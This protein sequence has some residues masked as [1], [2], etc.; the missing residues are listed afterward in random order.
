MSDPE[1][2][3]RRKDLA[4]RGLPDSIEGRV[5]PPNA[6]S[7]GR[8]Q[9][10]PPEPKPNR[11]MMMPLEGRPIDGGTYAAFVLDGPAAGKWAVQQ[12]HW[13]AVQMASARSVWHMANNAMYQ[14]EVIETKTTVYQLQRLAIGS[15][16]ARI[17]SDDGEYRQYWFWS[18]VE[19]YLMDPAM[20]VFL[21]IDAEPW[22]TQMCRVPDR[23]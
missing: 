5:L 23:H 18:S 2:E 21:L 1:T 12:N 22:Q 17:G 10:P 4:R 3:W 20:A 9:G 15:R 7:P 16:G 19:P 11:L 14:D 6:P 13:R 8:N